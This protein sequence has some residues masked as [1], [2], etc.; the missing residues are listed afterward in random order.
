MNNENNVQVTAPKTKS[1]KG[2]MIILILMV[3]ALAGYIAYDKFFS[4]KMATTATESTTS[5]STSKS[6]STST[7][8]STQN[9]SGLQYNRKLSDK[10]GVQAL[11]EGNVE[12]LSDSTGDVYLA[13]PGTLDYETNATYKA[14]LQKIQSQFKTYS[15]KNYMY[16]NGSTKECI[17]LNVSGVLDVLV[18]RG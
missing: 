13:I 7:S 1:N 16:M 4:K 17:R 18:L 3:V 10:K 9:T 5:E 15:P 2:L 12:V 8:E 11:Y 6:E 14:N